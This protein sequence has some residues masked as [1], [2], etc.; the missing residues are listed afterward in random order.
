[1]AV[2]RLLLARGADPNL[3]NGYGGSALSIGREDGGEIELFEFL[4]KAAGPAA[5]PPEGS[6]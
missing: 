3:G 1:V 6:P 5:G 4:S 2:I